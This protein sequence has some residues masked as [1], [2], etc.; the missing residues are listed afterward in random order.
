MKEIGV[1]PEFEIYDVGMTNNAIQL[2]IKPGLAVPPYRFS[3]VM[4][5]MGGIQ[6]SL[7]NLSILVSDLPENSTWQV[8]GIGRHQLQPGRRRGLRGRRDARGL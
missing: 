8:I 5:V 6:P 2:V 4:G 3:F 1:K 7:R